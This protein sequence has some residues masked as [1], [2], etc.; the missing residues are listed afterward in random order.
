MARD[1]M[2]RDAVV[3]PLAPPATEPA[4]GPSLHS[5][6]ELTRQ[7]ALETLR[8]SRFVT[9]MKRM[10]PL[11]AAGIL[12][13]VIAYSLVPRHQERVA[14]SYS[15]TGTIHNDL[16]MLKPRFSSTDAKG[17]PFVI[18]AT[19]IVQDAKNQNRGTMKDVEAD[20]QYDNQ[21]W[22][23]ATAKSGYF[24]A[25]AH[26][27]TLNGDIALFTDSGYELHTATVDVDL[28]KNIFDGNTTVTGHGP[29]GTLR[30]DRFHIDRIKKQIRLNGHVHTTIY[31]KKVSRR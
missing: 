24:D 19:Q 26:T 28:K 12:A 20:M 11:A 27:L 17:N 21:S 9:V 13:A 7:T 4:T 31:P 15:Q 30:A 23:N 5:W 16:A 3:Q 10:L 8:Y 1:R 29:L 14:L 18:T 2:G 25:D 22:M 6:T